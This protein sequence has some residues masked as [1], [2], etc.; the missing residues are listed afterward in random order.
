MCAENSG[1][2]L[3]RI[4]HGKLCTSEVV[5]NVR[6]VAKF[7]FFS[8]LI[9]V[10]FWRDSPKWSRTASFARF[11]NHIQRRTTVGK[12]PLDESSARHG[13]LYLKTH[14]A[15]KRQTSMPPVGFKTKI[16]AGERPQTYTLDRAATGTG[17]LIL[18]G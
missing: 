2:I 14:N 17:L 6:E 5:L 7:R 16:S 4:L 12:T 10:C 1:A 11:L 15:H 3:L 13:D 9:L 8:L 18:K